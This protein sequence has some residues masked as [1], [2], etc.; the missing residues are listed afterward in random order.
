MYGFHRISWATSA[1]SWLS[2]SALFCWTLSRTWTFQCMTYTG[3]LGRS[4][5]T[6]HTK[7]FCTTTAWMR[8]RLGRTERL[9][10]CDLLVKVFKKRLIFYIFRGPFLIQNSVKSHELLLISLHKWKCSTNFCILGYALFIWLWNY[11]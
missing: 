4:G 1:D 8:D 2:L 11:L 5:T 10:V 3:R 6:C 7:F 9:I